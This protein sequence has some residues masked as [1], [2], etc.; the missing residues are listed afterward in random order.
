M[1]DENEVMT[2]GVGGNFTLV[3]AGNHVARCYMLV[4]EGTIENN[5]TDDKGKVHEKRDEMIRLGFELVN[6]S[7]VFNE[8]KGSEPFVIDQELLYSMHKKAKLRKLLESWR[9]EVLTEAEAKAFNHVKLLGP[10]DYEGAECLVNVVHRESGSG[11][12][13]ATIASITPVPAGTSVPAGK[14]ARILFNFNPPFKTEV[15]NSL[16]EFIQ[17]KIKSSDEYIKLAAEY[18]GEPQAAVPATSVTT[19]SASTVTASAPVTPPV[20]KKLPF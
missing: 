18:A 2:A 16:P 14:N 11:N 4:K 8:D 10:A 6:T 9:G 20:K 7:H 1:I 19:H 13:Y 5:F 17:K 12:K 15:F 3:P